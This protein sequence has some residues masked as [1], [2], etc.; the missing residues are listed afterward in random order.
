MLSTQP[1]GYAFDVPPAALDLLLFE[2][3][4][5]RARAERDRGDD[6][7]AVRGY[8]SALQLWRGS[9]L[10]DMPQPLRPPHRVRGPLPPVLAPCGFRS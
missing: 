9:V 1:T 6:T 8:E 5:G 2:Q 4:L 10:Q 3:R 7:A